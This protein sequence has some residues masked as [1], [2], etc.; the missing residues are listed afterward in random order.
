[1]LALAYNVFICF[2]RRAQGV[3]YKPLADDWYPAKGTRVGVARWRPIE[4]AAKVK[5]LPGDCSPVTN[6][7]PELV[8]FGRRAPS[9]VAVSNKTGR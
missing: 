9:L 2:I 8:D 7:Y 3:N 4:R 1:M 6:E 5:T